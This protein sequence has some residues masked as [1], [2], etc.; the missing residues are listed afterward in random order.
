MIVFRNEI[1]EGP[2]EEVFLLQSEKLVPR[3]QVLEKRR[4]P[5]EERNRPSRSSP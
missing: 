3:R 1:G 4:I 2:L 5:V